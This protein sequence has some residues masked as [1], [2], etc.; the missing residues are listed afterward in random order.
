MG[1]GQDINSLTTVK[2][3]QKIVA[4][5]KA[6]PQWQDQQHNDIVLLRE[7]IKNLTVAIQENTKQK[8]IV[9]KNN[10]DV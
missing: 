1:F 9:H 6:W 3:L 5:M 10:N 7:D 2:L 8:T 4:W